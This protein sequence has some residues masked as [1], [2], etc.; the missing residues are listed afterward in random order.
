[1]VLTKVP[2]PLAPLP[3]RKN[4]ACSRVSAGQRV[5]AHALQIALQRLVAGW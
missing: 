3:H 5:A 4:S 1:M 2:L